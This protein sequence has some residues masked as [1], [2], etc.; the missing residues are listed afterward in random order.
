MDPKKHIQNRNLTSPLKV[1]T[2]R[3]GL[4]KLGMTSSFSPLL[5]IIA[6]MHDRFT[7]D[8]SLVG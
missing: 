7:M 1:V 8:G 5:T 3:L 4:K 2:M 6:N